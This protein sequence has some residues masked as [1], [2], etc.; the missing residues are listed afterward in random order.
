MKRTLVFAAL[1]S[2]IVSVVGLLAGAHPAAAQTT[3]DTFQVRAQVTKTCTVTTNDL[4]FGQ[5]NSSQ[6]ARAST[7]LSV[8]CTPLTSFAVDVGSG[9]SGNRNDRWMSGPG[10]SRLRYGLFKDGG[11]TDPVTNTTTGSGSD[12]TGLS[13]PQGT[14]VTF[15]LYGQIAANQ[16]VAAGNYLD[17]VTVTVTY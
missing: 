10:V 13:D 2:T 6:Q 7:S 14:P 1:L 4:D 12:F 5:Y 17:T 16:A 3:T 9:I 8:Q 15:Q 11:Y